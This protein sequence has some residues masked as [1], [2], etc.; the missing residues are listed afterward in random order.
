MCGPGSRWPGP[1]QVG[2]ELTPRAQD[3]CEV[4]KRLGHRTGDLQSVVVHDSQERANRRS[5]DNA[6]VHPRFSKLIVEEQQCPESFHADKPEMAQ[7]EH[8]G[9]LEPSEVPDRLGEVLCIRRVDLA[10]DAQDRAE[11][12]C[13]DE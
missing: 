4:L 2:Q 6:A 13:I 8:Q 10:V 11:I 5:A 9:G 3:V 12:A 7:V 1:R